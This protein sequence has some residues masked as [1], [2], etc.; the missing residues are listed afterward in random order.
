[1]EKSV[2]KANDQLSQKLEPQEVDSLVQ[3]LRRNDQAAGNRFRIY[4]QRFE[5]LSSEIQLTKA[6]ES[7]GF[8]R[9]LSIGMYFKI[10]HDVDDV[11]EGTTG[12][13]REY[14]RVVLLRRL[15]HKKRRVA[16]SRRANH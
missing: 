13:C 10:I 9:R 16:L 8:M 1:M 15:G 14:R 2:A 5:E 4:L 3:T 12:A 11:F 6:C 7:A